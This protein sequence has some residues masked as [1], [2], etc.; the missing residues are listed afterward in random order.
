M[1]ARTLPC[2][3]QTF[4]IV[5]LRSEGNV[6]AEL[7]L[8]WSNQITSDQNNLLAFWLLNCYQANI[9]K[10]VLIS[11]VFITL[12]NSLLLFQKRSHFTSTKHNKYKKVVGE[13]QNIQIQSQSEW[14]SVFLWR[15]KSP[16]E[17]ISKYE[18]SGFCKK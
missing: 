16:G 17:E 2:L 8:Y 4:S 9:W 15:N 3:P 7:C 14:S 13:N 1:R 11:R 18:C 6:F 5:Q 10:I 12:V